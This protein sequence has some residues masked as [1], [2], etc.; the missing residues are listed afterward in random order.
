MNNVRNMIEEERGKGKELQFGIQLDEMSIKKQMELRNNMWHGMVD[1]GL[2]QNQSTEE[3]S[4]ALVVMLVCINGHFKTPIAYYFIK[5]LNGEA[6]ANILQELIKTLHENGI[7][8][9]RS[10][11]FDGASVNLSM[12]IK[13]GAN[14]T[15]NVQDDCYIED[16]I[17][18][19]P[20]V[21][22]PDSC[23]MLKLI[24]NT[25]AEYTLMD[26]NNK[27]IG[28]EFIVKLVDLQEKEKLHA[29]TKIRRRHINYQTEKMKVKLAAQILSNRVADALTYM[30]MKFPND[31]QGADTT[32]TFCK[33]MNDS[34]DILNSRRKFECNR[35]YYSITMDNIY[36]METKIKELTEYISSLKIIQNGIIVPILNSKRKT[37]FWGFIVGMKNALQLAKYV[38]NHNLMSYLLT[39]KLSQDHLE[40]F[41]SALR[42]M[43][44]FN[45]NP[46]CF[47]FRCAYK[48]LICHVNSIV[49]SEGNCKPQDNTNILRINESKND[50]MISITSITYDHD[51]IGTNGWCW[52]DYRSDI[53][54]YIAGFVVRSI[55]KQLKCQMCLDS[56]ESN[57]I[58]NDLIKIKN[59]IS[60]D[61]VQYDTTQPTKRG[62][63]YPSKDV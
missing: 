22:I 18:N 58:S 16:P 25:F 49:I 45:N 42:K 8:D 54:T 7:S 51:Y 28:W 11:T 1:I 61:E 55:K 3:A 34:F 29:G 12:V 44:G 24:R 47:Q 2:H 63:I 14:I 15:N 36:N 10:L 52:N 59:R 31:F 9:I 26:K 37:G 50:E 27:I 5:S 43:G 56:L 60:F 38:F 62:L 35:T 33:N 13:L 30:E 40:T 21:I 4:Y 46:T 48:K 19:E 53:V 41:F 23:H 32:S 57:T 6:R 20:I 39:Y 17:T